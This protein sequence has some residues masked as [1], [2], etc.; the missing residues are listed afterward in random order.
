ML[1]KKVLI[2][3]DDLDLLE[4]MGYLLTDAGYEI[5]LVPEGDHINEH[6]EQFGPDLILM[7]VM[8]AGMD[9]R[10]ICKLLKE[11]LLYKTPIILISGTHNL[12]QVMFQA[13]AP[14]DFVSKPFDLDHLLERIATQLL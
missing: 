11:D 1:L 13:G 3:D 14:D 6:I 12:G 10:E 5:L 8:L 2:V 4:I 9:G 7:D